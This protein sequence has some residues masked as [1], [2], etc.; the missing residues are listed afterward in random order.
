[1]DQEDIEAQSAKPSSR[2]SRRALVLLLAFGLFSGGVM[3]F[4]TVL[5]PTRSAS[6]SGYNGPTAVPD[7]ITEGAEAPDF[8]G[9]TPGGDTYRLVELRGRPVAINFWATWCAPCRVEMPELQA[10]FESHADEGFTI[11]AVNAG[12]SAEATQEF[13]DELG[14]TFPAILDEKGD[15]VDLY[16]V[17]VFPTTIWVDAEGLIRA[18]HYGPLTSDMIESY[19]T[20]LAVPYEADKGGSG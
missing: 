12:D 7:L 5:N 15:I 18:E 2:H 6:R 14:L 10:A 13:L 20:E 1:M 17:R 16:E 8:T 11:L 3:A 4:L 9:V 19:L